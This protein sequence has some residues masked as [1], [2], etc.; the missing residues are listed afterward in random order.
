MNDYLRPDTSKGR[1]QQVLKVYQRKGKRCRRCGARISNVKINNRSS[2]F[3][4]KCQR[5]QS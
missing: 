5:L 3:C 4:P 1:Y 2:Y